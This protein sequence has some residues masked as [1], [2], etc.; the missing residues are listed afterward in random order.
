MPGLN[1]DRVTWLAYLQLGV[2]GYFLYGFSPALSLLRDDQGVSRGVSALHSTALALGLL[3]A[4]GLGPRVVARIGR[5]AAL[6][7]G[8]GGLC[9]GV[10]VLCGTIAL[11]LTLLGAAIA[12]TCGSL[13]VN[14]VSAVLADHH[15]GKGAGAISE[16]NALATSMGIFAPLLL[17]AFVTIGIGWRAGLLV[18]VVLAALVAIVF[19]R[20]RVPDHRTTLA[21]HAAAGHKL[22]AAYWRLWAVIMACA[23]VE[24]SMTLWA[25]DLLRSRV[26][27]GDGA[28]AT[29]V[30][31]IV[32]GMTL[33]RFAGGRLTLRFATDRLLYAALVVNLVGFALFWMST[34]AWLSFAGLFVAGLGI[35]LQF[36]LVLV[37][38]IGASAGRPDLASAR[39][40]LAVG[41]AVATAP[42]ALGFLADRIGTH[43]AFLIVPLLLGA[44]A[45]GLRLSRVPGPTTDLLADAPQ[46]PESA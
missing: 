29:G 45:L 31:A 40:A 13:L 37:R 18:T 43:T 1:R 27:L 14:T 16:A 8:M 21:P 3:V 15:A 33:G 46:A 12:G 34:V 17:G 28:A 38:A 4:G 7:G 5:R 25:S 41:L 23:G 44:A 11:P 20:A 22:S 10:A 24:F 2:Y 32:V 42:F 9:V 39:S 36:P 30:T 6:W 35:A 26:G 19:G